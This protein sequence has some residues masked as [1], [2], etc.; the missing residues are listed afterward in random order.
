MMA[1]TSTALQP[2]VGY[3]AAF[4]WAVCPR[5]ASGRPPPSSPRSTPMPPQKD[6]KEPDPSL[7][8]RKPS[9][10][11]SLCFSS[12]VSWFPAQQTHCL[13]RPALDVCGYPVPP[14]QSR[15]PGPHRAQRLHATSYRPPIY[16]AC[17]AL[18]DPSENRKEALDKGASHTS[19]RLPDH[20]PKHAVASAMLPCNRCEQTIN[21]HGGKPKLPGLVLLKGGCDDRI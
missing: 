10:S 5:N 9:D 21:N 1:A 8:R 20:P 19:S 18:I 15:V 12:H 4:C 11:K 2:T 6:G 14:G 13:T 16:P 7:I 17:S 3:T